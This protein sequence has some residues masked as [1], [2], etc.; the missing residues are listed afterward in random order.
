MGVKEHHYETCPRIAAIREKHMAELYPT[1]PPGAIPQSGHASASSS[2]GHRRL[3]V[4]YGGVGGMYGFD[5]PCR[6][7]GERLTQVASAPALRATTSG[8]SYNR[9]RVD[10]T[11][12][13]RPPSP[14][15][16]AG[17]RAK[18]MK[19]LEDRGVQAPANTIRT[20]FLAQDPHAA[21]TSRRWWSP[22]DG[23]AIQ[24]GWYM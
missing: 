18:M 14:T 10:P 21:G 9:A 12:S 1:A 8:A 17:M 6:S 2:S 24:N 16:Y 3:M 11:Q 5:G 23:W 22:Q 19:D 20:N 7:R 15:S 4:G 13:R